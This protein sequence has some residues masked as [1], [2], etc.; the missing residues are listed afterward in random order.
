[1]QLPVAYFGRVAQPALAGSAERSLVGLRAFHA[2]REATDDVAAK[3]VEGGTGSREDPGANPV[4][5]VQHPRRLCLC[6]GSTAR[7][8]S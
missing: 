2:A 1:M 5:P 6:S 8:P 4:V 7:D 3:V